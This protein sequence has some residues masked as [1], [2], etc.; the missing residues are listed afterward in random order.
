MTAFYLL[1][2]VI[3]TVTYIGSQLIIYIPAK[4]IYTILIIILWMDIFCYLYNFYP[5]FIFSICFYQ[6]S[7]FPVVV[8]M[9]GKLGNDIFGKGKSM[10]HNAAIYVSFC[11]FRDSQIK[12]FAA[13]DDVVPGFLLR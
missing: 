10:V 4:M 7:D 5:F 6:W 13:K 3:D 1:H 12:V 9:V 11:I 2:L 8:C